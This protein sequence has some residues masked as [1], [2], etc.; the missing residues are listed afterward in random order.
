ME[1]ALIGLLIL[2]TVSVSVLWFVFYRLSHAVDKLLDNAR[3]ISDIVLKQEKTI[4]AMH[5]R[6]VEH[7]L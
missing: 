6:M 3:A 2:T 7:G 5:K 4:K 1:T